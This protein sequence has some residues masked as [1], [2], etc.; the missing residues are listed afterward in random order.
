MATLEQL[1]AIHSETEQPQAVNSASIDQLLSIQ[2]E[3][4]SGSQSEEPART[5]RGRGRSALGLQKE[6]QRIT[7]EAN[8]QEAEEL[9]VGIDSATN[10]YIYQ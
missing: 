4:D 1:L 10:D 5:V 9:L 2:Q 3:L 7:E 6:R 8:Q